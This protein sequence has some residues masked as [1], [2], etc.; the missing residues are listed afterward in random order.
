[1]YRT[2]NI[3]CSPLWSLLL[4]ALSGLSC[5]TY[6]TRHCTWL[7]IA[8]LSLPYVVGIPDAVNV[9]YYP[10]VTTYIL[11]YFK[12][13]CNY[14]LVF[15]VVVVIVVCLCAHLFCI[16][17]K[18][19]WGGQLGHTCYEIR[20]KGLIFLYFFLVTRSIHW[21]CIL[22]DITK[23]CMLFKYIWGK[24]FWAFPQINSRLKWFK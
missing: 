19:E 17:M 6:W 18:T 21:F 20:E 14:T 8:L 22:A 7:S 9:A 15:F 1:M 11:L 3:F 16:Y 13:H 24:V 2:L 5:L 10:P 12:I 23:E 4:F